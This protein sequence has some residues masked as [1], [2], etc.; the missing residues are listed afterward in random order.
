MR[1]K[2]RLG[3]HSTCSL[4]YTD[5]FAMTIYSKIS[6][7]WKARTNGQTEDQAEAEGLQ[8]IAA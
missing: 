4:R 1:I 5:P 6:S 3:S 8:W 2:E 7:R